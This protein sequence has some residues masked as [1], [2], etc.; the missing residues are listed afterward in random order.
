MTFHKEL[1]Q[2]RWSKLSLSEQM[3]NIGSEL[4]RAISWY[5]K[6]DQKYFQKSFE[7]FLELLDLTIADPR[8]KKGLKELTRLREIVCDI[9]FGENQYKVSFDELDKYFLQFTT[10]ARLKRSYYE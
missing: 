10:A 8:W 4:F 5:K 6:G 3:A 1:A 2:G 9:F 7:R